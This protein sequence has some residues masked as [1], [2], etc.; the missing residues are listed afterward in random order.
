MASA[1]QCANKIVRS[2]TLSR[3]AALLVYHL[4]PTPQNRFRQPMFIIDRLAEQKISEA[5]ARRC[6]PTRVIGTSWALIPVTRELTRNSLIRIRESKVC[7][8][9]IRKFD[10]LFVGKC[11]PPPHLTNALISINESFL[12]AA[13]LFLTVDRNVYHSNTLTTNRGTPL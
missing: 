10:R 7:C 1:S 13:N 6:C 12:S 5:M 11:Q 3:L 2:V 8:P 9:Q 4:L